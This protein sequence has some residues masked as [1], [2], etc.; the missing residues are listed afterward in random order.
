MIEWMLAFYAVMMVIKN[1]AS[2]YVIH[3]SL[4]IIYRFLV[5]TFADG[6]Y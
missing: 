6:F 2:T 3:V 5:V 4:S 1:V